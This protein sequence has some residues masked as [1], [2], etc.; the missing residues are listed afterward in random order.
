[1]IPGSHA[2]YTSNGT[3]AVYSP[4]GIVLW[5]SPSYGALSAVILDCGS[6]EFYPLHADPTYFPI[7]GH[8]YNC[9]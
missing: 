8:P 9:S 2:A 5:R 7:P 6:L 3:L 4:G 1:H